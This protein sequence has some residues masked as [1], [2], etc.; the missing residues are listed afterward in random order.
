MI[1][2][3][4][5]KSPKINITF[6]SCSKVFYKNIEHYGITILKYF[7]GFFLMYLNLTQN[8]LKKYG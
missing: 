7:K 8:V 3:F 4:C 2:S 1:G 5:I 6:E